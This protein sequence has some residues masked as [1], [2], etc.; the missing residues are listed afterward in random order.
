MKNSIIS[1]VIVVL[2]LISAGTSRADWMR[3]PASDVDKE[4][5]S[6]NEGIAPGTPPTDNSCWMA[7]ASNML[8]G[9]GY[10]NGATIQERAQD[11]YYDMLLWR[12]SLDPTDIHGTQDGGWMDNALNW[13]LGSPNNVWPSN[14]YVIV[15]EYG[16]KSYDPWAYSQGARFI[17]N[18]IRDYK[19][20]SIGIRWPRTTAGG[21][22]S[23]GHAITPWGDSGTAAYLYSNPAEMITADSDRDNGGDFQTYTYDSFTNP[24]PGGFNE[25]NGWYF[26]FSGNHTYICYAAT[27]TP[28]DSPIDPSDGPTQ[29]VVGSYRIDQDSL[30][31]AT[32]IHYTAYTD[33]DILAYRTQIDRNTVNEPEIVEDNVHYPHLTRSDIHV[34][35]DISD[36]PVPYGDDVTITTEFVLQGWNGIRYDDVYFT[37]PNEMD[38]KYI[39]PP[40]ESTLG[41]DVRVDSNDGIYR[42]LADDFPCTR[43]GPVTKI[44]LWNSWLGD[45]RT[46]PAPGNVEKL[47]L[48]IYSDDPIGDDPDNKYDD[49]GNKFSMPLEELWSGS[50]TEFQ[51]SEY[52]LSNEFF[53]DPY[54][55]GQLGSDYRIWQYVVDI[56]EESAFVQEGTPRNPKIYWLSV[57]A[58][59]SGVDNPQFG[60]KTTPLKNAWNDTAVHWADTWEFTDEF[61]YWEDQETHSFKVDGSWFKGAYNC[62]TESIRLGNCDQ[63]TYASIVAAVTPGT[64]KVMLRFRIP[65]SGS[66]AGAGP[67]GTSVY[68][69]DVYQGSISGYDCIWD[70]II[71]EGMAP[72]TE[73]G[74]I[75]VLLMDEKEGCDGDIQVTYLEV[76][77]GAKSWKPLYYP[78]GHELNGY[79]V[80]MSFGIVTRSTQPGTLLPGFGWYINSFPLENVNIQDITGGY[81]VGAFDLM[82]YAG[83]PKMLGEYRFI[84]QHP[85]IFDPELFE[86]T[87]EPPQGQE[88][89]EFAARNFRFG[90][91]WGMPN[92]AELWEFNQWMTALPQ[93]V[94]LCSP[95]PVVIPVNW[96]G[97][98]P[99]PK[100]DITPAHLIPDAPD[101]TVY[102]EADINKDCCVNVLDFRIMASQW[103]E[104]TTTQGL[105]LN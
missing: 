92:T 7:A 84:H 22:P 11:I 102:L 37:Y 39:Q 3:D 20:V 45:G 1:I 25:G 90:H 85:Y 4:F 66:S 13:W 47:S 64:D 73:D 68:V 29:K 89:C 94:F 81:V 9:A 41:T 48:T 19:Q 6:G 43:T 5:I 50:F 42:M 28:A 70:E 21:S 18:L 65:W 67:S 55:D 34:D 98:L 32:D 52:G 16:N 105:F 96:D 23:G 8:A 35:W 36:N 2:L 79:D 99:Y 88:N 82:D 38:T 10:G 93:E 100:S 54:V 69:D 91:T 44:F 24:N 72:Y 12:K 15:T 95:T 58:E 57:S 71:L 33:Y 63:G 46:G 87:I 14:P 76:Y 61:D 31:D 77:S 101:C 60:W 86:F 83:E 104:C 80:N 74:E 17:G 56:P 40:D 78:L 103:L 59:I 53:W 62:A 49:P 30:E 51:V 75:Q 26:N 27:L 97:R